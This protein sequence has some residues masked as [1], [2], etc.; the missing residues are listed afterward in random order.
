MS[1]K[2]IA[3]ISVCLNL[4]L[5]GVV[6]HLLKQPSP[7][8]VIVLETNAPIKFVE[9]RVEVPVKVPEAFDWRK[10][11]S[12]DYR[13]YI[14]NL[15]TVGCPEQTVRDIIIADVNALFE[16]RRRPLLQPSEDFKFWKADAT[17]I[18]TSAPAEKVRE[19]F[20]QLRLLA[21]E[22]R[23][24]LHELLGIDVPERLQAAFAP[25]NPREQLLAFLAEEKRLKVEEVEQRFSAMLMKKV[26]DSSGNEQLS[27]YKKL[28]AEKQ[29]EIAQVLTP[30]EFDEY[31]LRFSSTAVSL[32]AGLGSL[33]P[34][35]QEFREMVRIRRKFEE[36]SGDFLSFNPNEPGAPE[37]KAS[38]Q[39]QLDHEMER[40]FGAK[41]YTEYQREH[42]WAFQGAVAAAESS[43]LPP[44]V[45]SSIYEMKGIAE[46]EVARVRDDVSLS[47]E[48]RRSTLDEVRLAVE[49]A[50]VKVL[51]KEAYQAYQKQLGS[52]WLRNLNRQPDAAQTS[53]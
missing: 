32:R 50:V 22:K 12:E 38:A 48:E 4:L 27:N 36:Q 49:E 23:A 19:Q 24:V 15:R 16:A 37:R 17:P 18:F 47:L 7:P 51:G 13:Q 10:V 30:A 9:K 25:L 53:R 6:A 40:L 11:E 44:S 46:A 35:E 42:D 28:L 45:A 14:A 41:R 5:V 20:E 52:S 26:P 33:N 3:I 21:E 39:R 34:T 2:K 43:G 1:A 8:S 31:E 29:A